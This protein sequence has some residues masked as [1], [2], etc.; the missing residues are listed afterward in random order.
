MEFNIKTASFYL[1]FDGDA[2]IKGSTLIYVPKG[3]YP[4]GFEV[5]ISEGK[6][7]KEDD[8]QLVSIEI[9]KSGIHSINIFRID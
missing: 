6:V 2:S 4:N 8:K 3:H 1:E 5:K 9:Q 7:I